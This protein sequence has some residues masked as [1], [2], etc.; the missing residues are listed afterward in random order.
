MK[1]IILL[2]T[3][4]IGFSIPNH[5]MPIGTSSHVS[6]WIE[7]Y[8]YTSF[9]TLHAVAAKQGSGIILSTSMMISS[10]TTVTVPVYVVKG[11]G[12]AKSGSG[13]LAITGPFEAG[14]FKVFTGFSAGNITGLKKSYSEWFG[15]KGDG[16]TDD[17]LALQT[18][19]DSCSY[20]TFYL[21]AG[22]FK[23]T[24]YIYSQNVD[25]IG[26]GTNKS[27]INFYG[28]SA[29]HT[30]SFALYFRATGRTLS[31]I[32]FNSY[33]VNQSGVQ[34]RGS[35][36]KIENVE[37][38]GFPDTGLQLGWTTVEG[39]YYTNAN[40][41]YIYNATTQGTN[42]LW[43]TATPAPNSNAN[44]FRN[45]VV[46]GRWTTLRRIEG[47]KNIFYG[48]GDVPD[49]QGTGVDAVWNISGTQN[50]ING[51]Y[52]EL[53]SGSGYPTKLVRFGS[54]SNSN[55]VSDLFLAN[56]GYTMTS[57]DD[58]G[59]SNEVTN[60]PIGYNWPTWERSAGVQNLIANSGFRIWNGAQPW[61]WKATLGTVS[62]ETTTIHGSTYAVKI[63]G[64]DENVALDYYIYS[65]T[66]GDLSLNQVPIG[67]LRGKQITCGAWINSSHAGVGNVRVDGYGQSTHSGSGAWEWIGATGMVALN[68]TKSVFSIRASNGSGLTLTGD[69]YV[70][71]PMCVTGLFVPRHSPRPLNDNKAELMG[72]L[73]LNKSITFTDQSATPSVADGSRFTI[74]NTVPTT[75]TN[76]TNGYDGQ[77]IYTLSTGTTTTFK[78]NSTIAPISGTDTLMTTN[79][80]YKFLLDGTVWREY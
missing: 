13:T 31:G 36:N 39:A 9:S 80:I 79:K 23:T 43:V 27:I 49:T 66:A 73:I 11:G 56:A 7:S 59:W 62:R 35:F 60:K 20:G 44:T 25:I 38:K 4:V 21:G 8:L 6:P 37:I 78:N 72:P 28:G 67:Y 55:K 48:G 1:K 29:D 30:L 63:T 2:A 58:L 14:L 33:A 40:N 12:F 53:Q 19:V 10:A 74:A 34:F 70:S 24:N 71:E 76:F 54:A 22:T 5:A 77:T 51:S 52:V 68:A 47:T 61:G 75:I 65:A 41:I 17:V 32:T 69:I 45:V 3:L 15:A 16:T 50:E 42:G 57:I 18:G 46:F 64:A 26:A